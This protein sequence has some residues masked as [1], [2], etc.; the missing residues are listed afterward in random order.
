MAPNAHNHA[1]RKVSACR[2]PISLA[3]GYDL[4]LN[5]YKEVEHEVIAHES[6]AAILADLRRIEAEITQGTTRLEEILR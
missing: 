3:A 4:S 5:R 6:T 2:R 1:R